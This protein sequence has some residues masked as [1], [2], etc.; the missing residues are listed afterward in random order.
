MVR[1]LVTSDIPVRHEGEVGV[2]DG[3]V[4]S[5][6]GLTTVGVLAMGEE[7]ID[8]IQSIG[9]DG[10]VGGEDDELGDVRLY[11]RDRSQHIFPGRPD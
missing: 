9:L 1:N 5:H 11:M 3:G 6:L 7:L 10:I 8:S 2:V 4:V